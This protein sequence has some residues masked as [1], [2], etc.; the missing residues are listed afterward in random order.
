METICLLLI[1]PPRHRSNRELW[2]TC[3]LGVACLL[4][5]IG[6]LALVGLAGPLCGSSLQE[7]GGKAAT[8]IRGRLAEQ[9]F[10]QKIERLLSRAVAF[11]SLHKKSEIK[12]CLTLSVLSRERVI[13]RMNGLVSMA[14]QP[15]GDQCNSKFF[16]PSCHK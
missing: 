16:G 15:R 3:L 5:L 9:D 1:A 12:I 10:I 14:L 4:V 11:R 2:L 6:P 7:R 8:V 13:A